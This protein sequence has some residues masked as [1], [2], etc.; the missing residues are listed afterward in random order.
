[1]VWSSQRTVLLEISLLALAY[2]C[3]G[4]LGLQ[5]PYIGSHITL[6]WLPTGISV[7]ALFLRGSA[8][9]PGVYLGAFGVNLLIGSSPL[10]AAGIALGNTLGP[11]LS[12]RY[13]RRYD[14][15]AAFD[16]QKDVG[17]LVLAAVFGM[18]LSASGGVA[19]LRLAGLL[20]AA[21]TGSAWLTW[22][23]GD[24]IGVLLAAPVLLTWSRASLARIRDARREVFVWLLVA[25][26]VAWLA[27][28]QDFSLPGRTLPFAFLTLPLFAWAALRFGNTAAALAGLSYSVVAAWGTAT[29]HGTFSLP[30]PHVSLMLLWSYMATTVVTGLVITALQ[31]ERLR[32]E[33][34]LRANEE[35][36][37]GLFQLSPLGI[38]LTDMEGRYVEFNDAFR[39]ICGYSAAE[40]KALDYWTLT[41]SKYAAEEA[42]QLAALRTTGR[43]GPYEKEYLRKDGSRVPLSL[44]GMLIQGD[45]GKQYIWS[46]VEDISE[47]KRNELALRAALDESE[48]LFNNAASGYHSL[49]PDGTFLRINDTELK[50]L[51]YAREELVGRR[52]ANDLM[53]PQS[54]RVFAENFPAFKARGRVSDLELEFVRK[55][56][57]LLPVV[58]SATAVYDEAGNYVGSRSTLLDLSERR[59]TQAL[60]E[61]LFER[62]K[63]PM[64]LIDPETGE[65][66]D[67]NNA[68]SQFYGYG[69]EQLRKMRISD[70]NQLSADEV[71]AEMALALAEQRD[72]F[73]FPHR[74]AS[75]EIRQVEVHSGPVEIDRRKLLYSFIHDVTARR[76]IETALAAETARLFAYLQTASDGVHI[77]DADGYLSECSRSFA[78]ML[79]Y[80]EDEIKGMHV[81]EWDAMIPR[82]KLV[83]RIR[84]LL[85]QSAK[86]ETMHRR[87]DGSLIDVEINAKGIVI[88]GR[89]YIYASSRDITERKL[90]QTQLRK[91]KEEA[92]AANIAKSRFL[93]TMSHEIR[94]PMNG[95]LGMAQMLLLADLTAEERHEY[96]RTIVDS[97]QALMALLNDILDLSKVESGKV[98][99]DA[100]EFAPDALIEDVRKLF[101]DAARAKGIELT[102]SWAGKSEPRYL[103]DPLRLR[104]M[105]LNLVGNAVKFTE[106]GSVRI[107]A[108]ETESDG[109]S[110]MLEF[111]VTDTGVGVPE[112]KQRLL[113]QP[114]SQADNSITRKYGGTGLGLSIVGSFAR[115][116]G[117]YVGVHSDPAQGSRF[118]FGCRV[119]PLGP[120]QEVSHRNTAPGM[121]AAARLN[122]RILVVEDSAINRTVISAMLAKL[123]LTVRMAEDG[124]KG[125]QALGEGETPDLILMDIQMPVM[126]GYT[127]VARIR[128]WERNAGHAR[129]PVIALT[130]NAYD[131][132]RQRAAEADMDDFLPKP[133]AFDTLRQLLT[134]WLPATLAA[135]VPMF[136]A[137]AGT[138]PALPETFDA[139]ALLRQL[140][141]DH[142]LAQATVAAASD[143]IARLLETLAQASDAADAMAARHALHTLRGLSQQI[144]APR[145]R[146]CI[147]ALEAS[148]K[149]GL[150]IGH[151]GLADLRGEY[152]RLQG[153]LRQWSAGESSAQ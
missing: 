6:I 51:G 50:W 109:D 10:L 147:E 76:A 113:F 67:A 120:Q 17:T 105:L 11:L 78:A 19:C 129:I 22:W 73:Y 128:E 82:E 36:L 143:D 29:G 68:A 135:E 60:H 100:T 34:T 3:S 117:G 122:G 87:K 153:S 57:T 64:L 85:K 125:L 26:P 55:D 151:D 86:F 25:V 2:V 140:G 90:A 79:G 42:R 56:G 102:A 84:A 46:I 20:P 27:F 32:A 8:V 58:V 95:I 53:T 116:M 89:D 77:L 5:L 107:D 43:Y 144:G 12:A 142:A 134:K 132:D 145:L 127:A 93:A 131:E 124:L 103:G 45:D 148:V 71:K 63:I 137:S 24:A 33:A 54:Q 52:Q 138:A 30:D 18:L 44:N 91:A 106:R 74:L 126:D 136:N 123:G 13:L 133:I 62:S 99:L 104:Q 1:M 40:L 49:G 41:P 69:R 118:W 141:G 150:G 38:A 37:R 14:F 75:G 119:E 4:W 110:T 72:C 108:H 70:I 47:R 146:M 23:M 9:W 152:A 65:L 92:E 35:K 81:A 28:L 149:A 39:A 16:Q 97:G 111:V 115:L 96:A 139:A 130:A 101:A 80:D 88:D 59:R 7:A 121:A 112:D 83:S 21:A 66:V 15:H 114:F 98:E 48:D 94:T 31:A 61:A